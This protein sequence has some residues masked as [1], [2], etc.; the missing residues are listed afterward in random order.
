LRVWQRKWLRRL[1]ILFGLLIG[2]WLIAWS[3]ARWIIISSPLESADAILIL[4][5]SSTLRERTQHA[6]QLYKEQRAKRVLLTR[7]TQ[8]GSWSQA[9]QRN[10]FFY[11]SAVAELQRQGIP[12]EDIEV[13][14][15][16]V[17]STWDEAITVRHYAAGHNLRSLLI[18]T[19]SYHSRRA[20]WTFRHH[21]AGSDIQIG[22][23]PVATGIQT[24]RPAVWWL[25]RKGWQVVFLEYLKLIYY[26]CRRS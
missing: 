4:S 25:S 2:L 9:E 10:P 22:I 3:A 13:I 16:P 5:G 6:A 1:C 20:L 26:C 15:Q 12:K 21:F 23:D 11:E 14:G 17:E 18:V 8:R 7:D 19:S 24:P